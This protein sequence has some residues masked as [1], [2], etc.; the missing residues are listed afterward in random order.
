M[1]K[2]KYRS[3]LLFVII[4]CIASFTTILQASD[5]PISFNKASFEELIT[6]KDPE[7]TEEIAK[8]IID[9]RTNNGPFLTVKEL[10]KVEGVTEEFFD[11]LNPQETPDGDIVYDPDPVFLLPPSQC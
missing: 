2:L 10:L 3:L 9:Y 1:D 11:E 5:G 7:I 8:A 4:I 6:I